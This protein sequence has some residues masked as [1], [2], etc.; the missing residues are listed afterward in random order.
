MDNTHWC[1]GSSSQLLGW[2]LALHHRQQVL[3]AVH[4]LAPPELQEERHPE[5]RR[6]SRPRFPLQPPA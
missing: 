1:I 4:P 5:C 2:T 6:H 3:P